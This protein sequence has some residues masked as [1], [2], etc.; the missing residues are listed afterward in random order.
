MIEIQ[1]KPTHPKFRDIE[2]QTFNQLTAI[3]FAGYRGKTPY[4]YC[5]CTC[6]GGK[7]IASTK[8]TAGLT[9]S[10]GC[11]ARINTGNMFRRHGMSKTPEHKAFLL[12]RSR[13]TNPS[14]GAFSR[15]GARGIEFRFESFEQFLNEMGK[16]PS[17]KHSVDR[18]DNNGHY[19]HGNV[20]W[21]TRFTQ[22]QNRSNTIWITFNGETRCVKDWSRTLG[23]PVMTIQNRVWQKWCDLC[24]LSTERNFSCKHKDRKD[25]RNSTTPQNQQTNVI[26]EAK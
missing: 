5:K 2:G 16:R 14:D 11:L 25:A 22:S 19:E 10:C 12:A 1:P 6:G 20:R 23:L 9:K 8:I 21:A 15:Y 3:T 26:V 7:S 13:C 17:P 18:I 24:C 4:W